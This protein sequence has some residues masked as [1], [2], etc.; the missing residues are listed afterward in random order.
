MRKLLVTGG[1]GFIGSNFIRMVL[2][3]HSDCFVVN[4]DKLTYAGNLENLAGLENHPNHKFIKGDICDGTL[5][6]NIIDEYKIDAIVNFAAESHVDRS[7]TAPKIFIETNVAGTLTLLE[8]ARDKK[9]ERFIQISTD[10]VYGALGTEGKFT[11]QTPLS[12]NSPYSA[13]KAAA[14]HL[15]AAFGHTWGLKYNITRC[16]NNYGPY[17]FPEKMIPLM[18]NNALNDKPLPVYGDGLNVRDWIYV[19]DHCRAIWKVLTEGK[20]GEV[21][22]IG[23]SCEK[24][25]IEIVKTLLGLLKKPESLITFVKDRPGHDRRYA[26]DSSKIESQLG[27]KP[28]ITFE[29]GL[30][31]TIDW[32]LQN[33]KWLARITSGQYQQY[34]QQ[35]YANR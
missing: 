31:K 33:K 23:A 7:I 16:S 17:Q 21:Y 30:R 24:T 26:M 12:P 2:S 22:N 5:I 18:I 29:E 32:Y 4:L 6:A 8:A 13:S 15:V 28:L 34:Y 19:E 1:A 27:W 3:E 20:S 10:E 35:M 14:D 11:E 25:N 9:L